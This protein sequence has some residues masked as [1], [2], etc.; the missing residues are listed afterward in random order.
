M[1]RK[2]CFQSQV[3][4]AFPQAFFDATLKIKGEVGKQLVS[5]PPEGITVES[6]GLTD[7]F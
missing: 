5:N 4:A 7:R 3:G 6:L 1:H 2:I